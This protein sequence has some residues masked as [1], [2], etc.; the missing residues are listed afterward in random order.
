[1]PFRNPGGIFCLGINIIVKSLPQ[2]HNG[3]YRTWRGRSI[4]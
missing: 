4:Q 3:D 2:S 1:M